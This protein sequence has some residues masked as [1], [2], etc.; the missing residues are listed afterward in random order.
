MARAVRTSS[1][2]QA[3]R[4]HQALTRRLVLDAAERV[5]ARAGYAGARM[6]EVAAAA[7]VSLKTLYALFRGK[8]GLYRAVTDGRRTELFERL[9]AEVSGAASARERMLEGVAVAVRFLREHPDFLRL[10]LREGQAW[11]TG[12]ASRQDPY[13]RRVLALQT[14]LYERGIAEGAFVDE[15]PELLAKLTVAIYQVHLA[16]WLER[17]GAA[18]DAEALVERIQTHVERAFCLPA[19]A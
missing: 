1:R 6:Q 4:A 5:F 14:R 16:D 8:A 7:G 13:W 17:P 9:S 3:R 18:G 2:E 15:D 11:A 19:P 12:G 10:H